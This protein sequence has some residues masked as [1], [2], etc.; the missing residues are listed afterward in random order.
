MR[1][2][3]KKKAYFPPS[4]YLPS[5]WSLRSPRT[6][7]RKLSM[8]TGDVP[9]TVTLESVN[10]VTFTQDTDGNIILHCPQNDGEDLGSDGTSEPVHKRLR[11][12]N[13]DGEDPQD[14]T[15]T[16]YSVVTLPSE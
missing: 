11:L 3:R 5:S 13:E 6:Q 7:N 14:S 15:S 16:E 12:S 2:G 4:W 1:R 10:S 8:N 9:A